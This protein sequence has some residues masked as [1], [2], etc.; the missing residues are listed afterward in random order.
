MNH[1]QLVQQMADMKAELDKYQAEL[2]NLRSQISTYENVE[3]APV[4]AS[5]TSRRK[6]LKRM[7]I[8]GIG[9]IGALGLAASVG[10]NNTVLA[11]TA[12]NN[13]IEA[14]GGDGG[15]GLRAQGG[16]APLFLVGGT[17]PG[18]PAA[19]AVA[20]TAGELY[21]DNGGNL[22]Y[23]AVSGNPGTWR[24]VSGSNTAGAFVTL[25]S[26]DRF[27]DTR[28][29]SVGIIGPTPPAT[30]GRLTGGNT[31]TY[32]MTGRNGISGNSALQIPNGATAIV[33][34]AG[35]VSPDAGG[36]LKIFPGGTAVPG[37]T[38][39]SWPDSGLYRT[40]ATVALPTSGAN[41]GNVS[42][43]SSVSTDFNL[44]VIGYYI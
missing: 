32:H 27:V 41:A 18:A 30:A 17:N 29:G 3:E 36:F 12:A 16:L 42:V 8:A 9:G 43:M 35:V 19:G 13:A 37:T 20:H 10:S 28:S 5:T 34:S 22:F 15:Y 14:V 11:E 6:L 7:A 39:L 2:T 38:V 44:D 23:C 40:G 26:P 33:V 25:S 31:F 4:P 1:K 24:R 21:V